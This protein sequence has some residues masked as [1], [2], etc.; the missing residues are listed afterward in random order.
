MKK[1]ER[2]YTPY[3]PSTP[4]MPSTVFFFEGVEHSRPPPGHY[5]Y[6]ADYISGMTVS[7]RIDDP[8]FAMLADLYESSSALWEMGFL[9][10]VRAWYSERQKVVEFKS[11]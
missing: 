2:W 8:D 1:P 6:R 3:T 7:F 5:V 9:A 11:Q 4:S 10:F